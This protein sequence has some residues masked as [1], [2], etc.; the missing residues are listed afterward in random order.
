LELLV[1]WVAAEVAEAEAF[2]ALVEAE[3][4]LVEA[5]DAEDAAA[6]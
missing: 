3:E 6:V 1:A 5:E 4:A 2:E